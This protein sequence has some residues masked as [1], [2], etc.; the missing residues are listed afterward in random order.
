MVRDGTTLLLLGGTT[1]NAICPFIAHKRLT[2]ITNSLP[3]VN[4][5]CW[6]PSI[7]L[8]ILGGVLNPPEMEMR[9]ALAEHSLSR[10]RADQLFIGTT[11]LHPLHGV[12][13]DDP[14]AVGLYR[15]SVHSSDEVIVL[16]D[17]TK[18]ADPAGTTGVVMLSEVDQVVTDWQA[19]ETDIQELGFGVTQLLIADVT[20]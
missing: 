4:A 9:G 8:V 16:A 3:V 10:L 7:Q 1:V 2:V 14:N 12:M 17:H 6:Y 13:T 11:G 18:F 15:R 19:S 20:E 5:L